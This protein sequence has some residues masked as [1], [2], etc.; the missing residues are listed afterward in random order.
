MRDQV[1]QFHAGWQPGDD[2]EGEYVADPGPGV[3]RTHF[4]GLG[5]RLSRSGDCQ[6]GGCDMPAQSE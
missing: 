6:D 3:L 5:P 2:L 1:N 4:E